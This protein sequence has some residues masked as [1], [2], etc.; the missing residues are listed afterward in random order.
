MLNVKYFVG[1]KGI[2]EI[3]TV[4]PKAWFVSEVVSV[5]DQKVSLE[6]TLEP[7]NP[8]QKAI[9]VN[10]DRPQINPESLGSVVVKNYEENEIRMKTSS[11]TGGLLVLSEIYY[12]PRW[13][14]TIDGEQTP[15]YQTNHVLRSVYVPKG[16]HEVV[17]YFDDSLFKT[18]R[19][20]S[21]ISL[22][23]LLF[24]IVIIHREKLEELKRFIPVTKRGK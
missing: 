24:L 6:R 17:F 18:T 19:L 8:A 13:I 4:L 11:G 16:E 9:V 3:G 15:I 10:Y 1:K 12:A 20:I 21:R 14:S 5:N 7:F 2:Q 23:L 22:T